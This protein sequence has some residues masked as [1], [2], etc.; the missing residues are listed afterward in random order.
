MRT[1][2]KSPRLL[3]SVH[4]VH[5][6]Y[7][8]QESETRVDEPQHYDS[9]HLSELIRT[10][11]LILSPPSC[12]CNAESIAENDKGAWLY[13][14]LEGNPN[15]YQALL[16]SRLPNITFL[17]I[18]Y[19]PFGSPK[20]TTVTLR[21]ALCTSSSTGLSRFRHLQRVNL[22]VDDDCWDIT[23]TLWTFQIEDVLPFFYLP[24][25]E[26]FRLM[27]PTN[28]HPLNWPAAPPQANTLRA[29]HLHRSNVGEDVLAQLLQ[30]APY[31]AVL[32]YDFCCMMNC[33]DDVSQYLACDGL[34]CALS[35]VKDTLKVLKISCHCFHMG[36]G[37]QRVHHAFGARGR[38]HSLPDFQ[39]VVEL[40]LPYQLLFGADSWDA[41]CRADNLPPNLSSLVLRD[42]MA[43]IHGFTWRHTAVLQCLPEFLRRCSIS[44]TRLATLALSLI[45]TRRDWG[46]RDLRKFRDLCRSFQIIPKVYKGSWGSPSTTKPFFATDN[47]TSVTSQ[48]GN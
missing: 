43:F 28:E 23:D 1:L 35:H 40:E 5:F 14:L 37:G 2:F 44:N 33:D 36:F 29:L 4:R 45:Q 15:L 9:S 48:C 46:K 20:D 16:I 18:P 32:T 7:S 17:E 13:G 34:D 26:D 38:L 22:Y 8:S 41:D 21:K 25:L 3:Q 31:L 27:I 19:D 10:L 6:L 11:D 42:D 24:S 39:H 47:N 12:T 30:A